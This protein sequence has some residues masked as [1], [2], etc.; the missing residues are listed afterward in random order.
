MRA[1]EQGLTA[2]RRESDSSSGASTPASD[3]DGD[4]HEEGMDEVHRAQAAAEAA[5]SSPAKPGQA[6]R[7][8]EQ[9]RHQRREVASSLETGDHVLERRIFIFGEEFMPGCG[10]AHPCDTSRAAMQRHRAQS[11]L[12]SQEGDSEVHYYRERVSFCRCY[13]DQMLCMDLREAPLP[14]LQSGF[15]GTSHVLKTFRCGKRVRAKYGPWMLAMYTCI[16]LGAFFGLAYIDYMGMSGERPTPVSCSAQY[17][18]NASAL[19]M[20]CGLGGMDCRPLE[21]EL[22]YTLRC[23]DHC[24]NDYSSPVYGSEVYTATSRVCAAAIHAGVIEAKDGGCFEIK[25]TGAQTNYTSSTRNGVVAEAYEGWFPRS[26]EL[27]AVANGQCNAMRSYLDVYI[28][29]VM[30]VTFLFVRPSPWYLFL[31]M[32]CS[33]YLYLVTEYRY[34][35]S[36]AQVLNDRSTRLL[37]IVLFGMALWPRIARNTFPDPRSHPIDGL[38]F[39]FLPFWF[40]IHFDMFANVGIDTIL[41]SGGITSAGAILG[42]ALIVGIG[43]PLVAVQ[44]GLFYRARMLK[45]VLLY[46]V[47]TA[48]IVLIVSIATSSYLSLHL[49]HYMFGGLGM[50]LF[51]GQPRLRYSIVLQ[52]GLLGL[53]VNGI[54]I[55]D[56]APLYDNASTSTTS[57]TSKYMYWSDMNRTGF[58]LSLAWAPRETVFGEW[59][60]SQSG[61]EEF[62]QVYSDYVAMN[63]G[64]DPEIDGTTPPIEESAYYMNETETTM[65][66]KSASILSS[67][68]LDEGEAYDGVTV[69]GSDSDRSGEG[70]RRVDAASQIIPADGSPTF[71]VT[72]NNVMLTRDI[73]PADAEMYTAKINLGVPGSPFL[74]TA[75]NYNNYTRSIKFR[76]PSSAT[77]EDPLVLGAGMYDLAATDFTDP[78]QRVYAFFLISRNRL[79]SS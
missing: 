75:G 28:F 43:T 39:Y 34:Y 68:S 72:G 69:G 79:P 9:G 52:A 13:K 18:S 44:L 38:L 56:I 67:V 19:D 6:A 70:R 5:W 53:L 2:F 46:A 1:D 45:E 49:H 66:A 31:V 73:Y 23:P 60:C 26:F 58:E 7:D 59:N 78:C 16:I 4:D 17:W 55:W 8:G 40:G 32:L 63:S 33:G 50:M 3:R 10:C 51:Q 47:G 64:S 30:V 25:F 74:L 22:W 54:T 62:V 35:S 77:S 71:W 11:D 20:D 37:V 57:S 76:M 42:I 36:F 21:T 48:V 65:A 27:R 14:R 15:W 29:L 12:E 41:T 24:L 61:L